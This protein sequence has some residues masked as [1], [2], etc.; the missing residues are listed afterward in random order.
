MLG[1]VHVPKALEA[2]WGNMHLQ[3]RNHDKAR[4]GAA[5][6]ELAV[7]LPLLVTLLLGLWEVGRM[8]EV[9]QVLSNAAREGARLAANGN[10]TISQVN[11][12]VQNYITNAGLNATGNTIQIQN[13]TKNPTPLP[14]DPSA[15][16]LVADQL[17]HLRVK[18]TLPFSNVKWVVLNQ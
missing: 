11:T 3:T 2:R 9:T 1:E 14:T 17:D 4:F 6:V 7:V 10:V 8:I 12:H 15:D 18:V 16:P 5:A 13:L